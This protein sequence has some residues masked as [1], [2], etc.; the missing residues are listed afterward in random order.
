MIISLDIETYGAFQHFDYK[1][2]VCP[3]QTVFNPHLSEKVDGV[4]TPSRMVPQC[5]VTLVNGKWDNPSGWEPGSTAVFD[6]SGTDVAL[7]AQLIRNADA[8]VGS[9]R[10]ASS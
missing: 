7:V 1:G 8:I 6:M 10:S 4:R 3:D 2:Q 9:S 5:A